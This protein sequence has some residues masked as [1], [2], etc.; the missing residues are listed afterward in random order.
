MRTAR[1]RNAPFYSAFIRPIEQPLHGSAAF[2][3]CHPEQLTCLG[4]LEG[5]M[6]IARVDYGEC[7]C[8]QMNC[9]P[10]RSEAEWRDLRF[11]PPAS[12]L[13]G[14][15]SCSLGAYPEFLRAAL[16]RAAC[17]VYEKKQD[18]WSFVLVHPL[19]CTRNFC[20]SIPLVE[21]AWDR[22]TLPVVPGSRPPIR[23]STIERLPRLQSSCCPE[24]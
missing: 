24:V 8:L 3:F 19:V 12:N 21:P 5:E 2:P 7:A 23:N 1:R 20:P 13:T 10:D 11:P 15:P 16:E 9:H 18:P 17:A 4:Q 22:W 6:N 14:R